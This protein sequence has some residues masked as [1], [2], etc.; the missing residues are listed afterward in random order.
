M[1][2]IDAN[3]HVASRCVYVLS[4]AAWLFIDSVSGSQIMPC[5]EMDDHEGLVA[6]LGGDSGPCCGFIPIFARRPK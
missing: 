2:N 5:V 6:R 4:A 3:I 1:S